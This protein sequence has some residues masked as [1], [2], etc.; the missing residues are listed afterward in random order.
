MNVN[1][2]ACKNVNLIRLVENVD[3]LCG[4]LNTIMKFGLR[5]RVERL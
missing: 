4:Y 2:M 3:R 1:E 5:K